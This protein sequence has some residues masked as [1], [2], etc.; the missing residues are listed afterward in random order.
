MSVTEFVTQSN[1]MVIKLTLYH[2]EKMII[3]CNIRDIINLIPTKK[4]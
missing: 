2:V 3:N 4:G 1:D